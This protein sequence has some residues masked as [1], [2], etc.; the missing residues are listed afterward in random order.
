MKKECEVPVKNQIF[1][2]IKIRKFIFVGPSEIVH[3]L[4]KHKKKFHIFFEAWRNR[5]KK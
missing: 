5:V 2:C 3:S 1:T 4:V